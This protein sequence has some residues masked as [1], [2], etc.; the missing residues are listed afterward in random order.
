MY[1]AGGVLTTYDP[2][3]ASIIDVSGDVRFGYSV[4]L[5]SIDSMRRSQLKHR[6]LVWTGRD[7]FVRYLGVSRW[8]WRHR[9]AWC[10]VTE[11]VVIVK[12]FGF[13]DYR[14]GL[15]NIHRRTR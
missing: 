3:S 14:R 7:G 6:G 13:I 15:M 5:R 11:T 12:Q 2:V 8:G 4:C 9:T 10:F 1:Y